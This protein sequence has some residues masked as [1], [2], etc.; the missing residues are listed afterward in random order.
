MRACKRWR[1]KRNWHRVTIGERTNEKCRLSFFL[2]FSPSISCTLVFAVFHQQLW[3]FP[4]SFR[5][6]LPSFSS[7]LFLFSFFL[8]FFLSLFL[9][10]LMKDFSSKA[11]KSSSLR[12]LMSSINYNNN[13]SNYRIDPVI[14]WL[15]FFSFTSLWEETI[16]KRA[17]AAA[18]GL[19]K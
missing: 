17:A 10:A 18:N 13:C 19:S 1:R 5:S 11:G 15:S 7:V 14:S 8:S 4:S 16:F 3:I 2:S 6:F 12:Y 9:S